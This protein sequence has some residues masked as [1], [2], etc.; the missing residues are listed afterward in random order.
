MPI[1]AY[2]STENILWNQWN[3]M[4]DSFLIGLKLDAH[5][6]YVLYDG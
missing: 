1:K 4:I 2:I 6:P 3:L 5:I